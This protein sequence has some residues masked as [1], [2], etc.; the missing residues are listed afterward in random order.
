MKLLIIYVRRGASGFTLIEV[1][2]SLAIILLLFGGIY[3]I[4]NASLLLCRASSDIRM[5]ELRFNNLDAML[6][7]SLASVPLDSAVEL[8]PGTGGESSQLSFNGGPGVLSWNNTQLP[9]VKVALRTQEDRRHPGS[10]EF[11]VEHWRAMPIGGQRSSGALRLLDHLRFARWRLLDPQ[12][13]RWESVWSP[14][15][16]RPVMA[17]FS[18]Q[19]QNASPTYRMVFW[20]PPYPAT[21]PS[22]DGNDAPP[23]A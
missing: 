8:A 1:I 6:R 3:G 2:C 9:S 18:F 22:G 11:V 17:E 23:Q 5:S 14:D 15:Q 4:A 13:N 19:L 20:I 7:S 10:V 16:G 21:Q 12:T